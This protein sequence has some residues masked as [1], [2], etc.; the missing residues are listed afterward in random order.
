MPYKM[1]YIWEAVFIQ[2]TVTVGKPAV[3][4]NK[5]DCLLVIC[6]CCCF[7]NSEQLES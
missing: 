5:F 3:T 6:C 2:E 1:I 4:V 7:S